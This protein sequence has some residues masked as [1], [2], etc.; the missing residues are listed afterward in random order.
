MEAVEWFELQAMKDGIPN[1][2]MVISKGAGHMSSMEQ[3]EQVNQAMM[4]FLAGVT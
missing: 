2:Q 4:T 3:P 1:S